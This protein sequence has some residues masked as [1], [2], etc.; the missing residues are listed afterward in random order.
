MDP[1]VI[2]VSFRNCHGFHIRAK[3][4]WRNNTSVRDNLRLILEH[5]HYCQCVQ[6][7]SGG[8][9]G[10]VLERPVITDANGYI[11]Y[12]EELVKQGEQY[13]IKS[14]DE[15]LSDQQRK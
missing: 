15:Y 3:T 11:Y 9:G 6:F 8:K 5:N 13:T 12:E 10:H 14:M 2:F 7:A 4:F 1:L